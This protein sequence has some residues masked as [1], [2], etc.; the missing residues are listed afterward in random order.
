[1]RE[2]VKGSEYEAHPYLPRVKFEKT[3]KEETRLAV[4]Q[5]IRNRKYKP[6]METKEKRRHINCQTAWCKK[7]GYGNC[8]E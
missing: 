8:L 4:K 3:R 7:R 6:C 1:M 5:L 2:L